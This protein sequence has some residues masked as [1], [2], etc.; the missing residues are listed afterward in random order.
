MW[1]V[2]PFSGG[3]E[4]MHAMLD[5][6]DTDDDDRTLVTSLNLK[7][8]FSVIFKTCK[9]LPFPSNLTLRNNLVPFRSRSCGHYRSC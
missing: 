1:T 4:K 5:V 3:V 9:S 7:W 8:I 6:A 2:D